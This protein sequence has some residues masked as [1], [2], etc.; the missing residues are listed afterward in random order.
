MIPNNTLYTISLATFKMP[1]WNQDDSN[2]INEIN[3]NVFPQH[4]MPEYHY[5]FQNVIYIKKGAVYVRV[6]ARVL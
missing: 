5:V 4:S 2:V 6:V 3:D 1:N